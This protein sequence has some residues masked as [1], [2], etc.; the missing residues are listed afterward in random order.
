MNAS[1]KRSA[2]LSL[3]PSL[4]LSLC[5]F[6]QTIFLVFLFAD[7]NTLCACVW[8]FYFLTPIHMQISLLQDERMQS[9]C[10]HR[11]HAVFS[12]EC[13][14]RSSQAAIPGVL[15]REVL[16][17]CVQSVWHSGTSRVRSL[18]HGVLAAE[19]RRKEPYSF[20]REAVLVLENHRTSF[21][22]KSIRSLHCIT[23]RLHQDW[24]R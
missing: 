13:L 20:S 15:V 24:K 18:P 10:N 11:F 12:H 4:T 9:R 22:K 1:G 7:Q 23:R 2:V 3:S 16:L 19:G 5:Q 17:Q 14:T 8:L 21:W 6:T